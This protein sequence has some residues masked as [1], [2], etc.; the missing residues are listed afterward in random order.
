[1]IVLAGL[2][3]T[4]LIVLTRESIGAGHCT[5]AGGTYD[6]FRA[7]CFMTPVHESRSALPGPLAWIGVFLVAKVGAVV[8]LGF[9][10]AAWRPQVFLSVAA[11][12]LAAAGRRICFRT[13]RPS[14]K[15]PA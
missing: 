2:G 6:Y 1:V 10:S 9:R 12:G 3:I 11:T 15:S 4:P 8:M 13:S 14:S 7:L 5:A